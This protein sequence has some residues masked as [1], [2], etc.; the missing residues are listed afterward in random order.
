ML[1]GVLNAAM[2]CATLALQKCE[3]VPKTPNSSNL[4]DAKTGSNDEDK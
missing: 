3:P 1:D 4:G 2:G